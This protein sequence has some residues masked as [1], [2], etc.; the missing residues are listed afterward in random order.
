MSKI[1]AGALVLGIGI[2]VGY[3]VGIQPTTNA[4]PTIKK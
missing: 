1:L 2:V 3:A 4:K